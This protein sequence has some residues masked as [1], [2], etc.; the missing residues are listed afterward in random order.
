MPFQ[1]NA[2]PDMDGYQDWDESHYSKRR[3][4]DL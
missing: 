4:Q 2:L 1:W 3:D